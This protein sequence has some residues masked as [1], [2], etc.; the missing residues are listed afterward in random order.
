MVMK[1][2]KC[3]ELNFPDEKGE[4][5]KACKCCGSVNLSCDHPSRYL[6][7]KRQGFVCS[8]CGDVSHSGLERLRYY[9]D[10]KSDSG[11]QK[12]LNLH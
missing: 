2:N 8:T 10:S 4:S 11:L 5:A 12:T 9:A 3:N 1:C 7:E 6:D